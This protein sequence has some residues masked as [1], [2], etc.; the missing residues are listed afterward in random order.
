MIW[1]LCVGLYQTH[2]KLPE[3]LNFRGE[4]RDVHVENIEFLY[5][6]TFKNDNGKI[7]SEQ[8]IFDEIF[9]LID[10][11]QAYIL[12]DAFLFNAYTREPEKIYRPLT[13]ELAE[14]LFKKKEG[15]RNQNSIDLQ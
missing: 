11:A 6:V 4:E 12:I 13:S 15:Q 10:G 9:S 14:R 2:K 5:D 8:T 1:L 7:I 3:N